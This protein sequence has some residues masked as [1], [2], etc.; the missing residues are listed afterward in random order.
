MNV[1]KKIANIL[2]VLTV[3]PNFLGVLFALIGIRSFLYVIIYLMVC[4]LSLQIMKIKH[5]GAI[6]IWSELCYLA[7]FL[8]SNTY[9]ISMIGSADKTIN[10]I[11]SIICPIVLI[12]FSM[13]RCTNINVTISEYTMLLKKYS[14]FILIF[15]FV[16]LMFGFVE[17]S[18]DLTDTRRIIIGMRNPIWCSR[19]VGFLCIVPLLSIFNRDNSNKFHLIISV[20]CGFVIMI[21][22]GSRGPL[23]SLLLVLALIV[24]PRLTVKYKSYLVFIFVTIIFAFINLSDRLSSGSASYSDIE[25]QSLIANVLEAKF[26]ILK[27]I[28]I[29]SYQLFMTGIDGLYYPHNIFLETYIET[30]LYGSLFLLIFI[31]NIYK[32]RSTNVF[33]LFAM[34]FF[35]NAQ[36][37]GDI[38]GNNQFFVFSTVCLLINF[39]GIKK[40]EDNKVG[41]LQ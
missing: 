23:L 12:A 19:Y 31:Y 7:Y 33:F 21:H 30:G 35:I 22:T 10:I 29:G 39:R 41:N 14:P 28:G 13:P 6:G 34:F 8:F 17:N 25:R 16:L 18:E 15:L 38:T 26:D 32:R 37:S 27:G 24:Y 3:L 4:L 9:T 20:I 40:Y 11:Y 2:F 1:D 36:V 5:H